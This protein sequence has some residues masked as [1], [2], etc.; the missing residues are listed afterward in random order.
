MTGQ[1]LKNELLLQQLNNKFDK[2]Q[3]IYHIIINVC[4][5]EK[6]EREME[7]SE[8]MTTGFGLQGKALSIV[9]ARQNPTKAIELVALTVQ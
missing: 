9:T 8:V 6:I 4:K 1:P 5:L 2:L 3:V 7:K